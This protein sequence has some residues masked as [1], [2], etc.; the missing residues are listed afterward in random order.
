MIGARP[1]PETICA[2]PPDSLGSERVIIA[3]GGQGAARASG[4]N[5]APGRGELAPLL[6]G[7]C[8]AIGNSLALGNGQ[9]AR[10]HIE[11]AGLGLD[12]Q[13]GEPD[14]RDEPPRPEEVPGGGHQQGHA[15]L[16]RAEV[17]VDWW[18]FHGSS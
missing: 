1:S 6:A 16:A 18:G 2:V 9:Q 10:P 13:V 17:S 8:G 11:P 7:G 5:P 4:I 15:E 14:R 3:P 12:D